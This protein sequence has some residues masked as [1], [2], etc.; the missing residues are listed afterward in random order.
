MFILCLPNF[1]KV[2]PKNPF[3]GIRHT[4]RTRI[5]ARSESTI[6][7]SCPLLLRNIVNKKKVKTNSVL[8]IFLKLL[9]G[10]FANQMPA[11]NG[12]I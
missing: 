1:S 11:K 6:K 12:R 3:K 8:L 2:L 5:T 4:I 10:S 9:T 7:V